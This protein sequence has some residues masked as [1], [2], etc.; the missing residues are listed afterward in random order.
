M[1][2]SKFFALVLCLCSAAIALAQ[3]GT[4]SLN[5]T[6]S[7]PAGAAVP[8]ATVRAVHDDTGVVTTAVTAN[9]MDTDDRRSAAGVR[10]ARRA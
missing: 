1:R 8:G 3:V 5:G 2:N 9:R 7:D 10:P 4:G 6:V